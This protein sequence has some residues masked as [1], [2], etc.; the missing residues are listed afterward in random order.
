MPN[1]VVALPREALSE[2]MEAFCQYWVRCHNASASAIK[3]GYALENSRNQGWQLLQDLKIRGR[4]K[5]LEEAQGE[6]PMIATAAERRRILSE[7]AR[8]SVTDYQTANGL[9]VNANSPNARSIRAIDVDG[10]GKVKRIKLADAVA[11][12]QEHN[13][14]DGIGRD[15]PPVTDAR[16][17]IINVTGSETRAMLGQVADCLL[18][19]GDGGRAGQVVNVIPITAAGQGQDNATT[20]D[21]GQGTTP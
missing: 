9:E 16:T 10:S 15:S 7:I 19:E 12:I 4:I 20:D 3:A 17:V 14:M 2:R 21:S 5:E 18:P 13:K 11:A 1:N 6:D 8:A